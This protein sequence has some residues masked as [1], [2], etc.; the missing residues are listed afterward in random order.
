MRP[1]LGRYWLARSA[2][3][4]DWNP[5]RTALSVLVKETQ[6][7]RTTTDGRRT[8]TPRAF[9]SYTLLRTLGAPSG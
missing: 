5:S 3:P 6:V 9:S 4:T 2:T 8:R 1:R 7:S